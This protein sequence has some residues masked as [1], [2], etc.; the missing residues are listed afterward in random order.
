MMARSASSLRGRPGRR[1]R[2]AAAGLPGPVPAARPAPAFR[3]PAC[4]V[5][6]WS[7]ML[8]STTV[9]DFAADMD[10]AFHPGL[11]GDTRRDLGGLRHPGGIELSSLVPGGFGLRGPGLS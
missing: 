8:C 6:A 5:R 10:S 11:G 7:G 1:G 2:A 9:L 4:P 3:A